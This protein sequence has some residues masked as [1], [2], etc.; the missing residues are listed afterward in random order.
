MYPIAAGT[1]EYI[2]MCIG[3]RDGKFGEVSSRGGVH[4]VE[5]G[6]VAFGDDACGYGN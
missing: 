4:V 1:I 3:F 2:N 6:R 5:E